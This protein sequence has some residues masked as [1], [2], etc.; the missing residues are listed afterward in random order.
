MKH[1]MFKNVFYYNHIGYFKLIEM[2]MDHL[3]TILSITWLLLWHSVFEKNIAIFQM[4]LSRH[5]ALA[6]TSVTLMCV[7]G[8]LS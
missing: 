3:G 6:P 5:F 8:L 7:R 4:E 2:Y 1:L